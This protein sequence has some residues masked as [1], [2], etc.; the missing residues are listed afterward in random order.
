MTEKLEVTFE[1]ADSFKRDI[2]AEIFRETSAKD[3][4]GV[5]ELFQEIGVKLYKKHKAKEVRRICSY[6][7]R[8]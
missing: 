1:E 7:F 3:N 6:D 2:K 8:L 5:S 4:N